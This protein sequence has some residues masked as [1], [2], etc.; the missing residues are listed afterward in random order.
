MSIHRAV[1]DW[2]GGCA[3]IGRR[4][5][6]FGTA[7]SGGAVLMPSDVSDGPD[8]I[9]G[10]RRRAYSVELVRVL[11]L[12]L[13]PEDT[14]NIDMLEEMDAIAAWIEAKAAAG[15]YPELPE[16]CRVT[17]IDVF[18]PQ[19]V[20]AMALDGALARYALSFTIHYIRQG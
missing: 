11:P 18:D 9:D 20:T 3:G 16:G 5:F 8:Y 2:L 1:W 10:S 17:G 19:A 13:E 4:F 7:R 14:G 12:T 6:N 15:E